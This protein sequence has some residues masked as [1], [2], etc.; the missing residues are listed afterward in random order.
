MHI[1]NEIKAEGTNR[2]SDISFKICTAAGILALFA[3][4]R[5]AAADAPVRQSLDDAW[6][7]GPIIA[8][9]P[10]A[11]PPGDG[12]IESYA[13][14]VRTPRADSFGSSTFMLYGVTKNFTLGLIPV[15]G[16]N[17]LS[18]AASS[19]RVGVGDLS[20]HA[21][22]QLTRFDAKSG[23]PA[24]AVSVEESLPTGKY[25]HLNR[26][27]D[28]QGSGA[29]ATSF[30][31]YAQDVFWLPN[32]R[33]LRSRINLSASFSGTARIGGVSSYGT[34]AGF[35]GTARPG[36]AMSF[37]SG[38]EYSLTKRW[39][40][41]MDF[42]YRH[43]NRT[44]VDGTDPAGAVHARFGPSDTFAVAPAIEYSWT[45]NLGVL[46]G[47]RFIVPGR[48]TRPSTTPIVALSAFL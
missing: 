48:N 40:A 46:V 30:G 13:Y 31:F 38:W 33:I 27:S 19:S 43:G 1:C 47:A 6:W 10:N 9:S 37:D 36:G 39:V 12:Y 18:H 35:H 21:Q 42:Y 15:F 5:P 17:R 26:A 16:Y 14:D 25:Q 3:L 34:S 8:N 29:Y 45:P 11:L 28:G 32:G 22:Y 23:M 20:V 7:T 2:M 4:A 24:M 41:A 44:R